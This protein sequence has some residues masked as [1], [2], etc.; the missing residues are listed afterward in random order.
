MSEATRP[1]RSRAAW[2]RVALGCPCSREAAPEACAEGSS[3]PGAG[4]GGGEGNK[5]KGRKKE[6]SGKEENRRKREGEGKI[7]GGGSLCEKK[8]GEGRRDPELDLAAQF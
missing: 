1:A 4:W 8:R 2:A 5:G 3:G 7:R 6:E